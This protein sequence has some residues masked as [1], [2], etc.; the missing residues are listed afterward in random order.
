MQECKKLEGMV[1]ELAEQLRQLAVNNVAEIAEIKQTVAARVFNP[2]NGE[3]TPQLG[4]EPNSQSD[5]R[6]ETSFG[7]NSYSAST[8]QTKVDFPRF[9]GEDLRGWLYKCENFFELDGT[10]WDMKVRVA[11][12]I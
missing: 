4:V 3:D 2:V 11:T 12:V 7:H 9:S 1:H 8:R 6:R 10:P 5:W